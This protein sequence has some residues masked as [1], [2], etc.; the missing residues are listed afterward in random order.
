MRE[1]A[2]RLHKGD[3]LKNK[4]AELGKDGTYVVLSAVGC[5][6]FLHIRLAKAKDELSI[7]EDFEIISLNG[8]IANGK[9]HLHIGVSDE[10]GH[11]LVGHL[12]EGNIVNT[13]CELVLGKL[14][15]YDSCR[16]Y[17]K[18]TGYDEISFIKCHG[19]NE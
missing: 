16:T 14:Q 19:G 6:S 17:D 2:Y 12:L 9:C 5:L 8:T 15:E 10:K 11:C 7:G 13:T 3:D 18:E 4:I 1:F